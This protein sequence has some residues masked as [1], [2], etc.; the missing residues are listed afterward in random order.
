MEHP[1]LSR[2]GLRQLTILA[3]VAEHRRCASL[4]NMRMMAL[5]RPRERRVANYLIADEKT[6]RQM[7]LS[8]KLKQ[9]A[10]ILLRH[11]KPCTCAIPS[12]S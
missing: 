11:Y 8:P 3:I 12:P 4:E 6:R 2:F 9:A 10:G 5:L 1:K 7:K